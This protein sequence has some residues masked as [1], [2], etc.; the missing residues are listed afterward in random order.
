MS[1]SDLLKSLPDR[2]FRDLCHAANLRLTADGHQPPGDKSA[3]NNRNS[4]N[5]DAI[6]KVDEAFD[7]SFMLFLPLEREETRC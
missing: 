6:I 1:T 3:P 4:A 7:G 5:P 2:G